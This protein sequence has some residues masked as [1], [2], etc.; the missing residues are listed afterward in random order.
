[1]ENNK[2]PVLDTELVVTL[3]KVKKIEHNVNEIKE[4]ALKIQKYYSTI[5]FKEE[6]IEEATNERAKLNKFDTMVGNYRKNK[7]KEFNELTGIGD[8]IESCT[9][10]EK[11]IKAVS[12]TVDEQVKMFQEKQ[13]TKYLIDVIN[14]MISISTEGV[15]LKIEINP[16]WYNKGTDRT[17]I[18]SDIDEQIKVFK[19]D[20]AL[21]EKE[22]AVIEK[23][24]DEEKYIE[25][26]KN[27]RNLLSVLEDIEK[28]KEAKPVAKVIK[29]RET[30]VRYTF[31]STKENIEALKEYAREEL[32]MEVD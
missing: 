20:I 27:N 31:E 10:T 30:N 26:Y 24:T 21:M 3:P 14:P 18:Q 25:R 1:M 11:I 9:S 12:K 28:D 23:M 6:N 16:K 29:K 15:D 32:W 22:I 13:K 5:E 17:D 19:D 4:F 8:F 7:V 2:K